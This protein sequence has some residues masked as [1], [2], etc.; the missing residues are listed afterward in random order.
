M[1]TRA[2]PRSLRPAAPGPAA[3]ALRLLLVTTL[4]AR[5]LQQLAVLLL[6]H[7]LAALLD[8]G[9]HEKTFVRRVDGEWRGRAR[10]RPALPAGHST[11]RPVGVRATGAQRPDPRP[12]RGGWGSARWSGQAVST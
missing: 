12:P 9:T 3:R 10:S 11:R 6:R 5:L 1:T 7:A 8:D 4:D 2:T